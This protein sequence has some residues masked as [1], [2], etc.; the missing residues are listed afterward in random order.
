MTPAQT[1]VRAALGG[2]LHELDAGE[3]A[4]VFV[5]RGYYDPR[6]NATIVAVEPDGT[7]SGWTVDHSWT[8]DGEG[9]Q[10]VHAQPTHYNLAALWM[11]RFLA[12]DTPD[13]NCDAGRVARALPYATLTILR[14]EARPVWHVHSVTRMRASYL[15][16]EVH[17][18]PPP[19]VI[20]LDAIY[21]PS[22]PTQQRRP[23][24]GHGG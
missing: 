11:E 24:G 14:T 15:S 8:D 3:G 19:L 12:G 23:L 16:T 7:V 6:Y 17:D 9:W 21:G 5:T 22:I 20:A 2:I 18:A 1:N 10:Q 13:P 4:V